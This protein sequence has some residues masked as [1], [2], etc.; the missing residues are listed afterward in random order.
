MPSQSTQTPTLK[1]TKSTQTP[2]AYTPWNRPKTP[3]ISRKSATRYIYH[4]DQA[5]GLFYNQGHSTINKDK[6]WPRYF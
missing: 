5:D 1:E 4:L 2:T 6:L 3:T